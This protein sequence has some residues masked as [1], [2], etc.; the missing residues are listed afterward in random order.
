MKSTKRAFFFVALSVSALFLQQAAN[1]GPIGPW[2]LNNQT[3]TSGA[4]FI[5]QFNFNWN[6]NIVNSPGSVVVVNLGGIF[7]DP[8]AVVDTANAINPFCGNLTAGSAQGS[9]A[10]SSVPQPTAQTNMVSTNCPGGA[11]TCSQTTVTFTPAT[12]QNP[13]LAALETAGSVHYGFGI[14]DGTNAVPGQIIE[15]PEF[16]ASFLTVQDTV[17]GTCGTG[18]LA[19]C[20]QMILFGVPSVGLNTTIP[21]GGATQF[22]ITR[23]MEP[24]GSIGYDEIPVGPTY[25]EQW[26]NFFGPSLTTTS[27][28]FFLSPTLIPLDDLNPG[29]PVFGPGP[30]QPGSVF[31]ANANLTPEPSTLALLSAGFLG[32]AAFGIRKRL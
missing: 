15:D 30:G 4:L 10:C 28:G 16:E 26:T 17:A 20:T 3:S 21:Q 14:N 29:D 25:T 2:F 31:T 7:F 8:P 19:A 18:G 11:A 27:S 32:V 22:L 24:N 5:N 13:T 23:W 1:A 9:A 12:G 6:I